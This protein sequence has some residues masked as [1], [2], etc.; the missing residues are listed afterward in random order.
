MAIDTSKIDMSKWSEE[1]LKLIAE[2]SCEI[3]ILLETEE[4][5][6]IIWANPEYYK[7]VSEPGIPTVGRAFHELYPE[8]DWSDEYS[9]FRTVVQSGDVITEKGYAVAGLPVGQRYGLP[10]GMTYWNWNIIPVKD[11]DGKVS[12]LLVSS[13]DV[14][15][16]KA[17][18][19]VKQRLETVLETI[20]SAVSIIEKPDGRITLM[21]HRARELLDAV[22]AIG[23]PI[24]L[25][26]ERCG[27][28]R[29]DGTMFSSEELPGSS[30]FLHGEVVR[31]VEVVVRKT[32]GECAT[33]LVNAA[34]MHDDAGNIS[35]AVI[36]FDDIT[37]LKDAQEALRKAYIQEHGVSEI[38]QQALLPKVPEHIGGF[39]IATGY[40]AASAEVHVGGDFFDV[41]P[42]PSGLIGIVIG[43]VSGK[44]VRAAVKTALTK[45]TL[46]AYAHEDPTPAA[47]LERLNNSIYMESDAEG[48]V[49]LFYGLLCPK[50]RILRF[51]NAGHERPLY[52]R[53][54]DRKVIELSSSGVVLGIE[55]D[56]KYGQRCLQLHDSDR[57]LLYT[58]GITEARQNGH[59]YDIRRLADILQRKG[60]IERQKFID[61]LIE[62]V[63]T[64]SGGQLRDDVAVLLLCVEV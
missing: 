28:F 53:H 51:A 7:N 40:R 60:C 37:P 31:A 62:A 63:Q 9:Y 48:F 23:M 3:I 36:A 17:R 13:L 4:P 49:T 45:Y 27:F 20:P 56:V 6:R 35:A 11:V 33:M 46:R 57:V 1:L 22:V 52:M 39:S 61:D 41:F 24:A 32:S 21:N 38:L 8:S 64:F 16:A 18:E 15:E 44:G 2:Y 47:V 30:A 43:D 29:P 19:L 12:M 10:G 55:P 26:C 5:F 34:P 59:F 25:H 58:D 54:S 50:E 42:L 14:S